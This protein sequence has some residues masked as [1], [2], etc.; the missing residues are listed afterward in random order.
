MGRYGTSAYV[1]VAC[2]LACATSAD[3]SI[4]MV[5]ACDYEMAVSLALIPADRVVW[6][7]NDLQFLA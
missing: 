5:L 6:C 3:W 1:E 4:R 7:L 2:S